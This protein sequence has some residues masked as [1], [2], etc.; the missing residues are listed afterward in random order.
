ML[1]LKI[2]IR[3]YFGVDHPEGVCKSEKYYKL[4]EDI[5]LQELEKIIVQKTDTGGYEEKTFE[6]IQIKEEI[7]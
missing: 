3:S 7:I 4:K 1:V 5:T 6:I 2:N